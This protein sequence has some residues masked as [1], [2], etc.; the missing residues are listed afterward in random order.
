MDGII[1]AKAFT[2]EAA[3]RLKE[4]DFAKEYELYDVELSGNV[5]DYYGDDLNYFDACW[6]LKRIRKA[7]NGE[8]IAWTTYVLED[9]FRIAYTFYDLGDGVKAAFFGGD[10]ITFDTDYS[11]S[12]YAAL[13]LFN[14]DE[15]NELYKEITGEQE[16]SPSFDRCDKREKLCDY[17]KDGMEW[18]WDDEILTSGPYQ[19]K[20]REAIIHNFECN[21]YEDTESYKPEPEWETKGIAHFSEKEKENLADK[22]TLSAS[23]GLA[24]KADDSRFV[25]AGT[26]LVRYKGEEENVVIPTGITRIGDNA[27]AENESIVSVEIPD[28]VIE[29]GE[30][31]FTECSAL[32]SVLIPDSVIAIGEHAFAGC[33]SLEKINLPAGLVRIAKELLAGCENLTEIRMPEHIEKIEEAAFAGCSSLN[34]I[35]FPDSINE[36]ERFAFAESGMKYVRIPSGVDT[37]SSSMYQFCANLVKPSIPDHVKHIGEVAFSFCENLEEVVLP[38]GMEDI[39][40]QAFYSCKKLVSVFIPESVTEIGDGVFE[41]CDNVV[42]S[43]KKDSYAEKYCKDNHLKYNC[44]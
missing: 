28:G 10:D 20:V 4:I 39:G 43:V 2:D 23:S 7:L 14:D 15:L 27:F 11:E 37:V 25:I 42:V 1:Y 18:G 44:M 41:E 9:D 34:D 3:A 29:I 26:E 8:G 12:F 17:I 40:D 32:C 6:I 38:D 19:K 22:K 13:S 5:I 16:I 30:G 21:K 35:S 31:V 36:V 33:S 24:K